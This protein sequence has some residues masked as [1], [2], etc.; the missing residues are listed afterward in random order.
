V[1]HIHYGNRVNQPTYRKKD[2]KDPG[3]AGGF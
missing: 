2:E 1:W 3:G